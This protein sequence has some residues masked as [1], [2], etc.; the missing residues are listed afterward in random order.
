MKFVD[1]NGDGVIDYGSKLIEDADGN[2]AYGDYVRIG[3]TTPRYEYSL[4]INGDYKGFDFSVFLQGVGKREMLGSSWMTVA[5]FQ[6]GDGGMPATFANDFWFEEKDA[7]GNVVASNYDAFYPRPASCGRSLIF[8]MVPSDRYMLNMAYLRIKNITLGYTL[9]KSL[10]QKVSISKARVY[11]SL[12][13]FFTFDHLRG[14]PVDPEEIAGY[15][16]FNASNYNS[17]FAGVGTPG[18]KSASFGVQVTF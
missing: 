9:P 1:V 15:S 16:S 10:T 5:G 4:M 3:N 8:N 13:N 12:E 17:G 14:L 18:Y 7:S 2:P 6:M 11:V